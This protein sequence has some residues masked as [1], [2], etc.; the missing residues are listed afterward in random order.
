MK[1]NYFQSKQIKSTLTSLGMLKLTMVQATAVKR[2][3]DDIN[4]GLN[5]YENKRQELLKVYAESEGSDKIKSDENG[6]VVFKSESCKAAFLTI[7][8]NVQN[9][10]IEIKVKQLIPI[11][12]FN[13]IG[14]SAFELGI[15]KDAI[16]GLDISTDEIISSDLDNIKIEPDTIIPEEKGNSTIVNSNT[17]K[18]QEEDK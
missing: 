2:L 11:G 9:T 8:D 15:L 4:L 6:N 1:S 16:D 13:N 7:L 12:T 3:M 5:L 10:E 14:I 17:E 18:K